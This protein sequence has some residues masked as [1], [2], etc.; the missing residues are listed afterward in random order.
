MASEPVNLTA[1]PVEAEL[2]GRK[3]KFRPIQLGDLIAFKEWV[4]QDRI[5][6]ALE[7]SAGRL[8]E[9]ER[10]H[11]VLELCDVIADNDP[12]VTTAMTSLIGVARLLWFA[13]REVNNGLTEPDFVEAVGRASFE[14]LQGIEARISAGR[15]GPEQDDDDTKAGSQ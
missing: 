9:P 7:A 6:L 14:E 10:L 13:A 8:S 12:A 2:G 5:R 4:R 1:E 3:L 11:L 15:G